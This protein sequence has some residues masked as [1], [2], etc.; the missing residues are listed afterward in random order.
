MSKSV[1]P[2]P[3]AT[4]ITAADARKA[5]PSITAKFREQGVD[6]EPVFYGSHRKPEAV[7]MSMQ[8]YEA[9]MS[10][11]EDRFLQTLIKERLSRPHRWITEEELMQQLGITEEDVKNSKGWVE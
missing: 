8:R 1:S 9:I 5:L 11:L 4:V 6:A 2:V 10:A 7:L 3:V